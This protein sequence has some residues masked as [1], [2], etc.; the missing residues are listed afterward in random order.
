[1]VLNEAELKSAIVEEL[2]R[3]TIMALAVSSESRPYA[4]SL[5]YA[6]DVLNVYWLSDPTTRHSK[7]LR[8]SPLAVVTIAG[9]C[10]D[11]RKIRGL[12]I[13]GDAHRLTNTQE[14]SAGFDLLL[15]RYPFLQQFTVGELARDLGA[16]AVYV[17]RPA[18]VTL[19]DNARGFG[20]KQTLELATQTSL[21]RR[22][23]MQE[24]PATSSQEIFHE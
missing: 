3:H 18:R 16:A 8:S 6:H 10:D 20:F 13:E 15:A 17:L 22:P 12:Q 23:A 7:I 24:N 9:Q 14:E 1:M 19:I 21:P 2:V 5:M 4:V 11:F